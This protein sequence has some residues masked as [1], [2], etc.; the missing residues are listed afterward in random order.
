MYIVGPVTAIYCVYIL[1]SLTPLQTLVAV[2]VVLTVTSTL[3][4]CRSGSTGGEQSLVAK[5]LYD[6]TASKSDELSF[7]TGDE[8][9]LAP[10][11]LQNGGEWLLAGR[12]R[13]SG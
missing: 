7:S 4:V 1:A 13:K 8:L 2:M 5:A 10:R 9:A 3:Y 12:N 11:P 6:F